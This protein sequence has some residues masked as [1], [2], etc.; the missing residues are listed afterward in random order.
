MKSVTFGGEKHER[1]EITVFNYE[2]TV[3][4]DYHDDNWLSVEVAIRC[5]AFQG[6]FPASFLTN[7]L[8]AFYEQLAALQRTLRGKAEFTTLEEQ[9]ELAVTGDGLGYIKISGKARDVAGTGNKLS[10]QID[11]DQTQLQAS[12]QSLAAVLAAYPVRT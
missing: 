1:L 7:E 8:G 5:G 10:F 4:G 3:S 2:R 12:V 6:Q 9:L 11:V